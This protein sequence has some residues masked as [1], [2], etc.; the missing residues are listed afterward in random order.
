MFSLLFLFL[1]TIW[2]PKHRQVFLKQDEVFFLVYLKTC[3]IL[4]HKKTNESFSGHR[5]A[6]SLQKEAM[7]YWHC[8]K[9]LIKIDV[10]VCVSSVPSNSRVVMLLGQ[11][12]R[13]NGESMLR[14][15]EMA[16]Q[17]TTKILH[18]IQ[19]QGESTFIHTLTTY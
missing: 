3:C 17:V 16:R 5:S 1:W 9:W 8:N 12:D 19:T 18:L 13:M 15:V 7:F 6:L 2:M 11:L 4:E 10:T 14:D